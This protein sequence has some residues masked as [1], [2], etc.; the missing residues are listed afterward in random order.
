V[1]QPQGLEILHVQDL[2]PFFLPLGFD[3]VRA[4]PL[5]CTT[6]HHCRSRRTLKA[7]PP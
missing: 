7:I 2:H 5:R 6:V 3:L 1:A 4:A